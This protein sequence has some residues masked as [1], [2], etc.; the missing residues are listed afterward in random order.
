MTAGAGTSGRRGLRRLARVGGLV[1]GALAAAVALR[2]TA[3]PAPRAIEPQLERV[4]VSAPIL[5]NVLVLYA[6]EGDKFPGTAE[7][8]A[9][10]AHQAALT[11]DFLLRVCPAK[12]PSIVIPGPGEPPTTPE[13]NAANFEAIA[14][15]SY[16]EYTAKPYWVPALV[17]A[18]DICSAELGAGW[19]L[20]TEAEVNGLD[21]VDRREITGALATPNASGFFGNFYF[22][23][24]IWVRADGGGLRVGNLAPGA[25]TRVTDLPVPSTSK[26]HYEGG[27]A[28]RCIRRTPVA[29]A[30]GTGGVGGAGGGGGVSGAGGS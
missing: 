22:G 3:G 17:D 15:C 23:L 9:T 1:V 7:A 5:P 29:D 18:V 11:Y 8:Q 12:Y 19:H 4:E 20:P 27:L 6:A 30:P 13:Q 25:T 24:Q 28:L 16:N 14:T 26:S 10:L 21:E 2:L